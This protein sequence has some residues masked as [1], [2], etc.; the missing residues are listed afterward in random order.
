MHVFLSSPRPGHWRRAREWSALLCSLILPLGVLAAPETASAPV[1]GRSAT[2]VLIAQVKPRS[3][4][5]DRKPTAPRSNPAPQNSAKPIDPSSRLPLLAV[6]AEGSKRFNQQQVATLAGLQIG[7]TVNRESFAAA[8]K[9]LIDTGLYETVAYRFEKPEDKNGYIV[10]FE[11]VET[12]LFYPIKLEEI[13]VPVEEVEAYL[14]SHDPVFDGNAAATEPGI[15]RYARLITEF[16]KQRDVDITVRGTVWAEQGGVLYVLFRPDTAIPSISDVRFEGSE[17]IEPLELRRILIQTA[18]G[19]LFTEDRFR[20]VLNNEVLPAYWAIG[21][22][23]VQ[24]PKIE[25]IPLSEEKGVRVMVTVEEGEE[26]VMRDARILTREFR[27]RDLFEL[28]KF[29]VGETALWTSVAAG[30]KRIEARLKREGFVNAKQTLEHKLDLE[31]NEVELTLVLDEGPRYLFRELKI[32]GLDLVTASEIRKLWSLDPG[33]PFNGLY[34]DFFIAQIGE[35][36]LMDGLGDSTARVEFN[37]RSHDA[38]VTLVFKPIDTSKPRRVPL[39]R[40]Q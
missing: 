29:P 40:P 27:E 24:F 23:G 37:E 26:F 7:Q 21:H 10:T 11:V 22:L 39:V 19:I 4:T 20:T 34:P 31:H 32:E 30:V 6:R 38:T 3:Q 18:T 16:L 8:H 25:A 15:E 13:P 17:K 5:S 12:E 33:K 1:P 14:R 36:Q 9:Q 28:A 35:R 2:P